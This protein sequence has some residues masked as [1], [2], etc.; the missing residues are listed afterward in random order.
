MSTQVSSIITSVRNHLIE[1]V[2]KFWTDVELLD[3]INR[4]VHDLWRD[5]V[6]LKQEH[7]LTINNTDVSLQ[8]GATQLSGVPTDVHKIYLIEPRDLN[9]I[10]GLSFTPRDY[11]DTRFQSLRGAS[12]FSPSDGSEILYAIHQQGAPVGSPTIPVAPATSST[13]L[14][15]F[16]Y[17]PTLPNLIATNYI[18]IP[19]EADNAIIAWAVAYARAKERDDRAP[20]ATWLTLYATEKQHLLESLGLRQY[21]EPTY[22]NALWEQYW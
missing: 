1:P 17:V 13:V 21:Q 6:D 12:P 22:V 10:P 14:L 19:G 18:P 4:G 3:Y 9:A 8:S 7:F 16:C 11:N 15:S 5:I 20:D 2:A